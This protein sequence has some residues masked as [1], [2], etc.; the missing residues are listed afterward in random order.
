MQG[1]GKCINAAAAQ[2]GDKAKTDLVYGGSFFKIEAGKTAV[3]EVKYVGVASS[4]EL[5]IDSATNKADKRS[6]NVTVSGL[7]FAG[8]GSKAEE[9]E[10]PEGD[11]VDWSKV[12]AQALGFASVEEYTVAPAEDNKSADITYE[13]VTTNYNNVEMDITE[14]AAEKNQMHLT[15]KNNGENTVN[16]RVNLVNNDLLNDEEAQNSAVNKSATQNGV[17]VRTDLEWGG[18]YFDIP[19]GQTAE[20][21]IVY[22][23]VANKL[24]LM[25]DSAIY[26]DEGTHSGDIT[27][28][29]LK[30]AKGGESSSET[31]ALPEA[32]NQGVTVNGANLAVTGDTGVYVVISDGTSSSMRVVYAN[33]QGGHYQN[34]WMDATAIARTKNVFS[35]KVTN[36]GSAKLTFR[37]DIE[38]ATQKEHTTCCNVSATQDGTAV[39]TDTT[40]GGSKF[41]IEAGATAVCKVTYTT[42]EGPTNVK[43]FL[44]SCINEDTA[45][46]TCDVTLSEMA[47]EGEG[48]YEPSKPEVPSGDPV[49]LTFNVENG[50]GYTVTAGED[51]KSCTLAYV[52]K[53]NTYKPATAEC[54]ALAAGNNTFTIKIKNNKD[55]AVTV[56]VD[57]QGTNK[58]SSGSGETDATNKSATNVGGTGLYTDTEWGGTKITIAGN[59][60]VTLVITYDESMDQGAVKNILIYVD[61]AGGDE[62]D[63]DASVTVSGFLFSKQD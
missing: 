32:N 3:C 61:S 63:H 13:G 54:A 6:G 17:A 38:S 40:W 55:T 52:G 50:S 26:G 35:V 48:S 41:E 2:D 34:L 28:S 4:V 20:L 37:V 29:E 62:N 46:Y 10:G 16:L 53:G 12:E 56:R 15:V 30:F 11:S 8:E 47:F 60:E 31:P 58:I 45:A 59:E 19:A 43:F 24:Q 39:F 23:G 25:I 5:M 18:S 27:V 51:N 44:D 21:V 57:V 42:A 49:A 33:L 1:G 9:P 22:E 7:K 14:A 36:N